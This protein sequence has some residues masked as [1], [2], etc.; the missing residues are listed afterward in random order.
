MDLGSS[1]KGTLEPAH[2]S[3]WIKQDL[4]K[5]QATSKNMNWTQLTFKQLNERKRHAKNNNRS[6]RRI[7]R[8]ASHADSGPGSRDAAMEEVYKIQN[9]NSRKKLQAPSVK[10]QASGNKEKLQAPSA[11]LD[12]VVGLGY[13]NSKQKGKHEYNNI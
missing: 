4:T 5:Q 9:K 8:P 10:L 11:K 2:I 1:S 12:K 7:N 13:Y 6:R 3:V